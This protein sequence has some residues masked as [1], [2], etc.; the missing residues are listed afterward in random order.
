MSAT[1]ATADQ[2][3]E[4]PPSAKLVLKVLEY[5]GELTQRGLAKETRLPDRTVRHALSH[6]KDAGLLEERIS[7]TDARRRVYSLR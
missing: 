3:H 2:L 4:L 6:L 1:S 7:F 5:N